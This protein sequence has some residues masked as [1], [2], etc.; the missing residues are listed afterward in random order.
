MRLVHTLNVRR[1]LR[2]P[3]FGTRH[4]QTMLLFLNI[5]FVGMS[6]FNVSVALVAMTNAESTNA[7]FQEFDWTTQQKSYIISSF[8]WGCVLTQLPGGYLSKRFG[9]KI[10]MFVCTFG[11]AIFSLLIPLLVP[12]GDWQVYCAIRTMQGLFQGALFPAIHEHIAKWSP[13]SER[14]TI[15]ALTYSGMDCANVLAML[16]SGLIAS[17]PLG[18]P[19]IS[20]ISGG[21]CFGW[22]ALWFILAANNPPES[23]FITKE[24][25]QYIETSLK[26][27]EDFHKKRIPVPWLAILTSVPFF[28]LIV[29]RCAEIWGYSTMQ[30]QI[31]SYLN[32]VFGMNIVSNAFFSTIPY[33][34]RWI[35]SYVYLIFG[36]MAVA[37]G[38][39]SLTAMRKIANTMALWLPA[40]FVSGIGFLDDANEALAIALLTL[41]VSLHAGA[42]MGCVLSAIDLS[43]NHAGVVMGIVNP[44]AN[45]ITLISPL[46]AGAVVTDEHN[47]NQWQTIFIIS[48]AI[49]FIGNLVFLIF[50]SAKVQPWDAPDYLLKDNV[51]E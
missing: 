30:T 19:G 12:W 14:N 49:F 28:A 21:L 27:E 38:W 26:R 51:E 22:C 17:S 24:E 45:M 10:V 41:N 36:N 20:Y 33:I 46:V 18:W 4:I 8:Y 25:C 34:A 35:M 9:T 1:N 3:R 2:C 13:P 48:A 5:A 42:T 47:R 37:R 29:A 15:G 32:G 11:S 7:N 6:S 43:P 16:V 39:L 44:L 31:P 40:I 50:G 23:R